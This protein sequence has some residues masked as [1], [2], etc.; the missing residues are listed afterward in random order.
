MFLGGEVLLYFLGVVAVAKWP[1]FAGDYVVGR[2]EAAFAVVTCGSHDLP[3]KVVALAA[4]LVAIAGSCETENDGVARVIQNIVSNSNIRFLVVC[5]EEV[6]GHAPGQT[7]VSLHENGIGPDYK[8]IGSEGTIPVLHPKY[9]KV[10][11][12]YTVV[13]RFRKQVELV[14]L[15][16]EK[17]PDSIAAKIRSLATKRVEKYSEPPL[18]PLPEEEKYDWATALRRIEEKG[19]L[20]EREVEPVSS[21]FYKRE[22]MV[23]DVAGVKLGGQRGE[24]ST[25]LAGTIFYRKEPIVRDPIKGIFDEK[26]A[27]ELIVR[28]TELSDE[29]CV[30]SMVHV[31]GETGE[32]L[33]N[34]MLFVADVTDAPIIIDSTSLEARVEAMMI[35]KEVGL[36]HKT[37]YNSVLSAEERELEAL[38]DVAPIEHAI[39]L[40]YGFTLD[41]RLKKADLILSSVRGVVEKAI[42]DPGVPILGE[43]GLEALHSAWTMKKL[44]GYPTAIGIH[45]M[46]AGVHHEL[47]RKMDFS[48]IYALPS[49][50]GVDLNLYGPMKNAPR[51]FPLVAAAE[52]AVADELHSVL[53]VHPRPTHPY[54]KVRETK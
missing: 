8:V 26:A 3:E 5:G 41:E 7:I 35:A 44:Y 34:Y 33:S 25:V 51:I 21:L 6:V 28:Q 32:A 23:Y 43:G 29:Y 38:R 45:N 48:F 36:E 4:D 52:A 27:E 46:L 2:E 30:P 17:N 11:D 13:E 12:P 37:I 47:R 16:G 49:L 50:Y 9:F 24:Y 15:R 14:D 54:Y 31:V 10:G 19:W 40:S 39:I 20:R 1:Y 42:L 22:L 18:L 53:G